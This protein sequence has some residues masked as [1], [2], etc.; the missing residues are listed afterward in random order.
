[1]PSFPYF[2]FK[3]DTLFL[4]LRG[5]GTHK[6]DS[7]LTLSTFQGV[8]FFFLGEIRGT[9][10]V[11]LK[12]YDKVFTNTLTTYS[13][14]KSLYVCMKTKI[15]TVVMVKGNYFTDIKFIIFEYV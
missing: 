10:N 1:M 11:V 2:P 6:V 4:L 13:L 3:E 9:T 15:I 8:C 7:G 5:R 12:S 14:E